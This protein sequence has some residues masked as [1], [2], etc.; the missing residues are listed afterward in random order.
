VVGDDRGCDRIIDQIV[1]ED[2]SRAEENTEGAWRGGK[3]KR[4]TINQGEAQGRHDASWHKATAMV[5][6]SARKI[7]ELRPT[8]AA[9]VLERL[10]YTRKIKNKKCRS[11]YVALV[12]EEE[13][14]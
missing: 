5:A 11:S 13:G 1:Q 12:W 10:Q 6:S 2:T 9:V 4:T 8:E 7:E 14:A 3:N